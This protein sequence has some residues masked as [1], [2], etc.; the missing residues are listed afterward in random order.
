M[1]L[2]KTTASAPQN[3]LPITATENHSADARRDVDVYGRN[4]APIQRQ[5]RPSSTP[6]RSAAP[7]NGEPSPCSKR[8]RSES[9]QQGGLGAYGRALAEAGNYNRLWKCS[10]RAHT[11]D[12]PDWRI[13]G[14]GYGTRPDGRHADAQR[15]YLT[16]LKIF[17]DEPSVLSNLGLS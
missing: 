10:S 16:A 3:S 17:P 15:Y 8:P 9:A 11:P 6:R 1:Q 2:G 14:A 7:G 4:I 12:Q 5:L 13:L